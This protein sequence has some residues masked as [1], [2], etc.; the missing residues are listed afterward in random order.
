MI[1]TVTSMELPVG[2]VLRIKKNRLQPDILTGQE[3]RACIV[4]GIHGDEMGSQYICYEL[5]R[6]IK[7]NY[8]RLKGIV[9]VYPALNPLGLD[10]YNRG[11]PVFDF[12]MNT[13]FP[14]SEDGGMVDEMAARIV[15]ELKGADLCLDLHANNMH[16]KEAPH[17]RVMDDQNERLMGYAKAMNLHAVWVHPSNVVKEGSLVYA[18]NQEGVDSLV[19]ES[20]IQMETDRELCDKIVNGI[21]N[22]MKK[23]GVWEG[24]PIVNKTIIWED[25]TVEYINCDST[26]LFISSVSLFSKVKKGDRIGVIVKPILGAVIEEITAPMDGVIFTLR[27]YP[28]VR[29]GAL[30]ARIAGESY[31]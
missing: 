22:V 8:E 25:D 23:M 26:G 10:T 27:R 1:E 5:I 12:D 4:A 15:E 18:M 17:V 6:R 29:E 19:I 2:E 30:I 9:D 21:L 24:E 20:G 3:K 28:S 11:F 16:V 13:I 7:E 31:D 14:G